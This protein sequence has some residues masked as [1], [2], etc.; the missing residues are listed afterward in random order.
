LVNSEAR[1][2]PLV[3]HRPP[4]LPLDSLA[5]LEQAIRHFYI[6]AMVEKSLGKG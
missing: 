6:K 5:A 2:P 4:K 1:R 3:R